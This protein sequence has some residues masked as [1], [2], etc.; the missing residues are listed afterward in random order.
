MH[1][2]GSSYHMVVVNELD[3]YPLLTGCCTFYLL[4]K[5][6]IH[7]KNKGFLCLIYHVY[8]GVTVHRGLNNIPTKFIHHCF[9]AEVPDHAF[10]VSISTAVWTILKQKNSYE[11]V[12]TL[13]TAAIVLIN[14]RIR[15]QSKRF[16]QK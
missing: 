15:Q 7:F 3:R 5:K 11:K 16:L 1:V 14:K 2:R 12:Q 4:K 9:Q 6:S 10:V 13:L 8:Q